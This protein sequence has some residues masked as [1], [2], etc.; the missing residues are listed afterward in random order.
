M[1][2]WVCFRWF[3]YGVLAWQAIVLI[4]ALFTNEDDRAV[5]WSGVGLVGLVFKGI[6]KVIGTTIGFVASRRYV[7]M[8]RNTKDGKLYYCP[9][10]HDLVGKLME[11]DET[12]KWADDIQRKYKP[13]DGWRKRDCSFGCVNIRYTPIKVAKAKGAIPVDRAVLKAAKRAWDEQ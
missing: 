6:E 3:T 10:W 11:Y 13:S 7:S 12:Y 8:M 4:V 9:S 2:G 1:S 5:I